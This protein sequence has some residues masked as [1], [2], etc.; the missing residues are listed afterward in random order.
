MNK[1]FACIAVALAVLAAAPAR[2]EDDHDRARRALLSGEVLPLRQ[3]LDRA[4]AEFGG[5]FI[6][7]ELE[8][9]GE[10]PVYEIKMITG[11]GNV[12][13][14]HYDARDGRLLRAKGR[15]VEPGGGHHR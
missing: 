5:E 3:I 4:Q 2:S 11:A 12:I 8:T 14:L 6:E 9:E 10:R 15:G 7:A 13:K 1:V